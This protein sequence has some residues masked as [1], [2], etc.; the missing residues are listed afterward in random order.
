MLGK[1]VATSRAAV[2]QPE[3]R[4]HSSHTAI[5]SGTRSN[6]SF[7]SGSS[8]KPCERESVP[9]ADV[10]G[11]AAEQQRGA[12]RLGEIVDS[13]IDEPGVRDDEEGL[14]PGSASPASE[15]GRARS[16][17]RERAR[18]T[19]SSAIGAARAWP[20]LRIQPSQP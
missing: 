12:E 10:G 18:P 17:G 11:R 13:R 6:G 20:A 16:G 3:R 4:R 8:A 19:M 15:R 14:Q 9:S 1:S 2:R 7:V 5:D